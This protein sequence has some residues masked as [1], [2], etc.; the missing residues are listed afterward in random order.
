MARTA[1]ILAA[2]M[3]SRLAPGGDAEQF[4]KPLIELGGRSLLARTVDA[5]RAAGAG[6]ILV[7]TGFRAPLVEEEVRRLD[8][9]DLE[10]VHNDGWR[11]ANGVSLLACRERAG[12]EPFALMMSDHIFDP[13]IL[14]DLLALEPPAG[15]V[16]LAVDRKV[17]GVFDLDDATKVR[18][19]DGRIV[20]IGK[21]LTDYNAIDCGL[22]LCTPAIFGELAAVVAARGDASLSEGMARIGQAGLF[23]PFDIG[24][25]WWQD[26]DT[27][28]MLGNAAAMLERHAT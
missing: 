13:S 25:R 21:T 19:A 15:S 3:G 4:S 27:P 9:G 11:R 12:A 16:T 2:G 24:E 8:R 26:V 6:R 20:A 18:L 1:I 10:T 14:A 7:V 23:L 28:E 5:C 17:A 22:F